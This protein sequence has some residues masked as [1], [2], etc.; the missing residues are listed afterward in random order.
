MLFLKGQN[1]GDKELWNAFRVN[2]RTFS[3]AARFL[4]VR[5]RMPVATLYSYC[6][7]VDTIAD[8]VALHDPKGA[9]TQLDRIEKS[10][11]QTF[12]GHAPAGLLW[13]RLSAVAEAFDLD[14]EAMFE[15]I[16]GARWDLEGRAV[17]T[18][19]DLIQYSELVGGCVGAMM[20]PFLVSDPDHRRA[21][22]PV[23]RSMGV[24]MQITNIL[25]DVGED[26]RQLGRVY[27]PR[28]RLVA[29]GITPD[30]LASLQPDERYA[31]L[32]EDV[33][34]L[35]E[36]RY[37]ESLAT[38]GLL[39]ASY[40]RGI[41]LAGRF[42]REILNEVRAAGYDNIGRRAVVPF[43]RKLLLVVR[44]GYSERRAALQT[45]VAIPA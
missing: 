28:R 24:A 14:R 2:S 36:A 25:R 12:A 27:L 3:L 10:L 38:I 8:E 43:K 1:A 31:R 40:R 42:Y 13:Q 21:L 19:E 35:A 30:A 20:L 32:I 37:E 29:C 45:P 15:L 18:D 23:A 34:S 6:R 41:A 33:A 44:D 17:E 26:A 22:R 11:D 7:S 16:E 9:A 4:P 39:P 5:V